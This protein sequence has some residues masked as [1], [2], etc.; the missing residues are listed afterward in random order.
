[1]HNRLTRN[2]Q[3]LQFYK[4]GKTL[5]DIGL[6]FGF[7]RSRAQQI[8]DKEIKEEIKRRFSITKNLNTVEKSA[9]NELTRGEVRRIKEEAQRKREDLEKSSILTKIKESGLLNSNLSYF[10]VSEYAKEIGVEPSL[11]H[12]Y[13][14][15]IVEKILKE[16]RWSVEYEKCLMCGKT[17]TPHRSKGYCEKCYHKSDIFKSFQKKSHINNYEKR[18][19]RNIE[20]YKDYLKRPEVI[21]RNKKK[22][23]LKFF[24][25][26][27]EKALSR[28]C[29]KCSECGISKEESLRKFKKDLFVV[30]ISGDSNDLDNLKTLCAKCHSSHVLKKAREIKNEDLSDK[31]KRLAGKNNI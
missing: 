22:N 17:D 26:N 4:E 13:F 5:E 12:K 29:Y 20:Y 18:K 7:T 19:K 9:L 21:E 1:M 30:R 10:S 16:K 27:R 8:I 15:E 28:D 23:D 6:I 25:G 2:Q 31:Y 24:D 11:V 3:I 14:P